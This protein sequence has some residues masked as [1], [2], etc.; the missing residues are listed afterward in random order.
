MT[1]I[2]AA[3]DDN[4]II[5]GADRQL[6]SGGLET[7]TKDSKIFTKDDFIIGVTGSPRCKQLLEYSWVI[8]PYNSTL[9]DENTYLHRTVINSIRNLFKDSGYAEINNN[10]EEFFDTIIMGYNKRIF[11]IEYNYQLREIDE[12]Y[13]CVG[14]GQEVAYGSIYSMWNNYTEKEYPIDYIVEEALRAAAYFDIYC[15]DRFDIVVL[16]EGL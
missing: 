15:N 12:P 13:I 3:K 4:G 7:N 11:T 6:T 14:S 16:K 2:V 8:P 10:N 9:E 1:I 5:M